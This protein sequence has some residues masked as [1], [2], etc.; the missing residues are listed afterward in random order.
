ME[1]D[2]FCST[3]EGMKQVSRNYLEMEKAY[4]TNWAAYIEDKNM[5]RDE[6]LCLY[7]GNQFPEGPLCSYCGYGYL[8]GIFHI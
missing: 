2:A 1:I 5:S 4:A 6:V 3:M 7:Q 8:L